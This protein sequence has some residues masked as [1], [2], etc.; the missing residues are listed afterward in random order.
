MKEAKDKEKLKLFL[1][2]ENI[3]FQ[4][5]GNERKTVHVKACFPWSDPGNFLSIRDTEDKEI[6][7]VEDL[8]KLDAKNKAALL[9]YLGQVN[10][11]LEVTKI[12]EIKDD[13]ELRLFDVE[14]KQGRRQFQTKLEDWPLEKPN[15]SYL[16][17]DLSGDHFYVESMGSL[18]EKSQKNLA[19]LVG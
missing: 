7:L 14:T 13:I 19:I 16:I 17:K 18:D 12:Y 10:F 3:L 4:M 15:G 5:D 2:N 8:S 1:T 6:F 9:T 11:L